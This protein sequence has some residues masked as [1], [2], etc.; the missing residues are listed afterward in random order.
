M[1]ILQ[2]ALHQVLM[3]GL[4]QV[5]M[6]GLHQVLMIGLHQLQAGTTGVPHFHQGMTDALQGIKS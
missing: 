5:S 1:M 6:I 2:Q 4:H 3:I